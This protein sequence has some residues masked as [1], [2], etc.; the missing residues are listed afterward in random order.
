MQ[1]KWTP[2]YSRASSV[3][4][5]EKMKP[6]PMTRSNPRAAKMRMALSRSAP[7]LGS[8]TSTSEPSSLWARIRPR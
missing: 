4:S 5:C 3:R 1:A 2:G 6:T 8:I 7:S